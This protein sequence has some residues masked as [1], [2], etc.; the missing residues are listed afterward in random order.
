MAQL[1]QPTVDEKGRS[2]FAPQQWRITSKQNKETSKG[3]KYY[4]F[5]FAESGSD[6]WSIWMPEIKSNPD[7]ETVAVGD[8][9]E[10]I[11]VYRPTDNAG[12]PPWH[13]LHRVKLITKAA[14]A[15]PAAAPA[16]T[17]SRTEAAA[18]AP[19]AEW[20]LPMKFHIMRNRSIAAQSRANAEVELA[21]A[22]LQAEP[23]YVQ[24]PGFADDVVAQIKRARTAI[25]AL[26]PVAGGH[27]PAGDP[28]QAK[29][30]ETKP[31][32][33]AT[34][35]PTAAAPTQ[36]PQPPKQGALVGDG[37]RPV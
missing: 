33:A 12:K 2:I 7:A 18:D 30:P 15:A 28:E 25:D 8:V 20:T 26:I 9:V 5:K 27:G 31:A 10:V 21:K 35:A 22:M 3:G 14:D 24:I 34:A 29:P 1:G 36:A 17:H 37:T 23:A 11:P 13:D 16:T 4:T 32:P 19:V 6:I